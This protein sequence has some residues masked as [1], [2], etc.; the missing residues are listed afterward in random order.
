MPNEV[1]YNLASGALYEYYFANL[2]NQ[3]RYYYKRVYVGCVRAVDFLLSL[4][5]VDS[6]RIAVFGGSQG[7][8]LS[9]CYSCFT[10]AELHYL[11]ALYPAL[12]DHDGL[13]AWHG[14]ADG[15]ICLVHS[16][17]G[18]LRKATNDRDGRLL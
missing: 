13:S 1:Y 18:H 12:S 17:A 15:R 3:N 9:H 4:P 7:G 8:A 6:S 14:Q 5:Q 11:A 2:D 16:Q 10:H